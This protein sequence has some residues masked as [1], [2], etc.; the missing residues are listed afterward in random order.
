M[1]KANLLILFSK[2]PMKGN[3]K[4]RIAYTIGEKNIE[5]F[6]FACLDDLISKVKTL[7]NIDFVIVPNTIGESILFNQRY[8]V[9]SVSLDQ[10]RIS[11]KSSKSKIF[12]ELFNYFLKDYNKVSLIPMD[13]PHIDQNKIMESFEKMENCNYV[14]GPESNGGVYLMGI[15]GTA[16]NTFEGVRWSTKDSFNDLIANCIDPT[17]LSEFFDL[18]NISDIGYMD[19]KML[20]NCPALTR[21]IKSLIQERIIMKKEVVLV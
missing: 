10:M 6:C 21:F 12:K 19:Q 4:S 16:G 20:S 15:K 17:K 14:F 9:S 3:S 13:I 7:N 5:E 11:F 1:K 2:W 8:N 18:N